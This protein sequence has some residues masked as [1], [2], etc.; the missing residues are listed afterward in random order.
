MDKN[1]GKAFT[2]C[3]NCG[4]DQRFC[5]QL[6]KEVSD[7]GLARPGWTFGYDSRSGVAQDLGK[8]TLILVGSTLPGYHIT[9]DV[10]MECGTLYATRM[11]RGEG[12]LEAKPQGKGPVFGKPI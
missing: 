10:C 7:R 2:N 3:P 6:G 4:S 5:E 12:R 8:Q 11:Q 1:F 9:T